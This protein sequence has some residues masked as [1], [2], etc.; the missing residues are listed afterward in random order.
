[1]NKRAVG[2]EYEKLAVRYLEDH[3]YQILCRNYRCRMGEIDLIARHEGYLVFVEVKYR[4]NGRDGSALEA[5]DTR[6][7]QRIIRVA[8]W[9]L[10]EKHIPE[11]QSVRFDVVAFDGDEVRIV[12]DAF[13]T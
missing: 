13:W 2:A 6:K 4:A 1:M 12:K 3:G 11:S 9:Y 8:R 10:M 5:V 7:Q